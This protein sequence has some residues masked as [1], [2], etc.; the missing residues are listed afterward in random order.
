MNMEENPNPSKARKNK[1][2]LE[3]WPRGVWV[4][5]GV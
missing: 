4:L 1:T 2:K 3:L 5:V